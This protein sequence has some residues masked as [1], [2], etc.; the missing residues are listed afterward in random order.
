VLAS[1]LAARR[2]T[3]RAR[4]IKR[5]EEEARPPRV[6][7]PTSYVGD[8]TTVLFNTNSRAGWSCHPSPDPGPWA[9]F[10]PWIQGPEQASSSVQAWRGS[11]TI[12]CQCW[13]EAGCYL[14]M[15]RV[16]E[17]WRGCSLDCEMFCSLDWFPWR[18]ALHG[19]MDEQHKVRF[20]PGPWCAVQVQTQPRYQITTPLI[21]DQSSRIRSS[22]L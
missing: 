9:S 19:D 8:S 2:A 10:F 14:F 15:V 3:L 5:A 17:D 6:H 4:G 11:G 12:S 7:P 20:H 13:R 1:W 16:M 21:L 22:F 18:S